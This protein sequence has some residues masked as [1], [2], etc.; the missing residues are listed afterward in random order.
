MLSGCILIELPPPTP[1]PFVLF[2]F[3]Y[4]LDN[5][6]KHQSDLLFHSFLFI[7]QLFVLTAAITSSCSTRKGN[8]PEMCMPSSWRWLMRKYD[9]WLH[10]PQPVVFG[11][12][13]NLAALVI[14]TDSV[15]ETLLKGGQEKH[16]FGQV[17]HVKAP[18]HRCRCQMPEGPL[19][20]E[21]CRSWFNSQTKKNQEGKLFFWMER[22][23]LFTMSSKEFIFNRTD[24]GP[25]VLKS[26]NTT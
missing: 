1:T 2:F 8:V 18:R 9:L 23:P 25:Q 15:K 24:D 26:T 10:S 6:I 20:N 21:G 19:W 3:I 11:S 5:F 13:R 7:M 16:R 22:A 17:E 4:S 12:R 14:L